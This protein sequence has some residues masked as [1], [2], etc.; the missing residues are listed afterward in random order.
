MSALTFPLIFA[1]WFDVAAAILPLYLFPLLLF[2][3]A[4]GC[5]LG[6]LLTPAEDPQLLKKFYRQVRPWGFWGPIKQQ[7]M[8]DDPSF[9]PNRHFKRDMFNVLL[10]IVAQTALVALPIFIVI[11]DFASVSVCVALLLIT[12]LGLKRFWYNTLED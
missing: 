7:V 5:V 2:V 4:L 8:A 3:S 12:M 9:V 11:K 10:G 6:S 1:D